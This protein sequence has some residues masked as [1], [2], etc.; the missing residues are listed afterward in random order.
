MDRAAIRNELDAV[1]IGEI[2]AALES[3]LE[4]HLDTFCKLARQR[5]K[6]QLKSQLETINSQIDALAD[7]DSKAGLPRLHKAINGRHVN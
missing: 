3:T 7:L 5:D 1:T 6:T 4:C 2:R